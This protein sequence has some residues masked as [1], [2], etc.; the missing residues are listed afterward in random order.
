MLN[1]MKLIVLRRKVEGG[2]NRKSQPQQQQQQQ[3]QNINQHMKG[4]VR[5]TTNFKNNKR[6]HIRSHLN[7]RLDFR[8]D[9]RLCFIDTV[10]DN[11]FDVIYSWAQ[12]WINMGLGCACMYAYKCVYVCDDRRRKKEKNMSRSTNLN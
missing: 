2:K 6:Q 5:T 3:H 10:S 7:F 12:Y 1:K 9:I 11:M 8:W 4:K